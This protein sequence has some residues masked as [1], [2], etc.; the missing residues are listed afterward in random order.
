MATSRPKETREKVP[1]SEVAKMP[2]LFYD[3]KQDTVVL[4]DV[5]DSSLLE[6]VNVLAP[7]KGY[8]DQ[9]TDAP[10]ESKQEVC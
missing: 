3:G 4:I 5:E 1:R 6:K 7:T 9:E 2:L 10:E 8:R